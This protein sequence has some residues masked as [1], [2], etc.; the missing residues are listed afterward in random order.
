MK[1]KMNAFTKWR[2]QSAVESKWRKHN[3]TT[4]VTKAEMLRIFVQE[5]PEP[6]PKREAGLSVQTF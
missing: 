6:S 3:T 2:G 4:H 5:L 1:Q